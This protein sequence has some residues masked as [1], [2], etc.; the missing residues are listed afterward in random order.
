MLS[1]VR[2][3]LEH[4]VDNSEDM[5]M[6]TTNPNEYRWKCPK[7]HVTVWTYDDH[8]YCA[9]CR[10]NHPGSPVDTLGVFE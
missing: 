2:K 10:T 7:G 8:Y 4:T 9:T 1:H 6:A 5:K 3:N